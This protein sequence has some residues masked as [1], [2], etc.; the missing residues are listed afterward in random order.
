MRIRRY[1]QSG[2]VFNGEERMMSERTPKSYLPPEERETLLKE[3]DMNLVYAAES[4][5]A[6]RAGDSEAGWAW[7]SFVELP[8]TA[9]R[10]LKTW[11][12]PQFIRDWGFRTAR[13]DAAYGPDWLDRP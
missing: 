1:R 2:L 12:G 6:S 7:L 13:A 4:Q 11:N 9:L 10:M 8:P 3:G 5:A